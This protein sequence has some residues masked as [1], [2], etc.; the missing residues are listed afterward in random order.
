MKTALYIFQEDGIT[1][2]NDNYLEVSTDIYTIIH[3]LKD[4][5]AELIK[6]PSI[7][8]TEQPYKAMVAKLKQR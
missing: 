2:A 5:A 1:K 4:R 7:L 8:D 6:N 3:V